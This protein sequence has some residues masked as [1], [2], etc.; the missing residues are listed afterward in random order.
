MLCL[1]QTRDQYANM[2]K[3]CKAAG[4]D[5]LAD[6]L[7][8]AYFASDVILNFLPAVLNHMTMYVSFINLDFMFLKYFVGLLRQQPDSAVQHT[9]NTTSEL[10]LDSL[11][12]RLLI[13]S[14]IAQVFLTSHRN[15]I[16]GKEM[17]LR[18]PSPETEHMLSTLNLCVFW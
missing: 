1:C 7:S 14:V 10:M 17:A 8:S 13:P 18:A 12:I 2:V 16:M 6:S 15:S 4:V 9:L 11:P 3:T 5:V